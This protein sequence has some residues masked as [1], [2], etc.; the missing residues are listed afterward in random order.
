M[1]Q[2]KA[3][4]HLR[5]V[6]DP[7][8]SCPLATST[9]LCLGGGGGNLGAFIAGVP[10]QP[11]LIRYPNSLVSLSPRDGEGEVRIHTNG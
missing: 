9:N 8:T 2:S 6:P 3:R 10:V 4:S 1:K 7:Y 11:V 5:T